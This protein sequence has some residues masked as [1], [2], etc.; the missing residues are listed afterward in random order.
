MAVLERPLPTRASNFADHESGSFLI[1]RPYFAQ[2]S[3]T[4]SLTSHFRGYLITLEGG[5][6]HSWWEWMKRVELRGSKWCD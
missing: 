4:T 2:K 6:L 5:V 3:S 1:F